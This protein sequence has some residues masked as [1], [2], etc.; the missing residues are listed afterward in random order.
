LRFQSQDG[1]P[2][3]RDPIGAGH[4]AECELDCIPD[5]SWD[6]VIRA[7]TADAVRFAALR[8]F[9]VALNQNQRKVPA[10]AYRAFLRS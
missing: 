8:T 6:V 4:A 9:E 5:E 1:P 10:A 3:F 7:E 2:Q